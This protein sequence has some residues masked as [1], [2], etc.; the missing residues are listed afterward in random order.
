[1]FFWEFCYENGFG[2]CCD[3]FFFHIC[4]DLM[5]QVLVCLDSGDYEEDKKFWL[6]DVFLVLQ[7]IFG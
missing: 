6:L 1:M 5:K 3:S 2:V 4:V 7:K